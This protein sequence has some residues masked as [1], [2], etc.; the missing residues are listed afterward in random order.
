MHKESDRMCSEIL[1]NKGIIAIGGVVVGF[2][3][4]ELSNAYKKSKERKDSKEAI[5]DEVR[6]NQEQ[7][8]NKI[9]ILKQSIEAL[10]Q[11]RFLSI[12][13]VKYSTTEY[14]NLYHIALPKL[15]LDQRDN[16]R[17]LHGFFIAIDKLLDSFEE[18]F[19]SDID[20]ASN[21]DNTLESVYD[22]AITQL[23]EIKQ[24]LSENMELSVHLLEGNP[25]QIF[26][27]E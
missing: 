12:K 27:N 13:C 22:A 11:K 7:T 9:D 20:N 5:F 14:D 4:S 25:L 1:S 2:L 10:K 19:K 18:S 24:S 15:S 21:R 26:K 8:K 17:H 23:S 3:L 6:F 16:L